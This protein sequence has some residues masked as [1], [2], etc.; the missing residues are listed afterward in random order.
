MD[1]FDSFCPS[2][3][4]RPF[5]LYN[6]ILHT[7][8]NVWNHR[9]TF[10]TT[11]ISTK[12]TKWMSVQMIFFFCVRFYFYR[13]WLVLRFVI[14]LF[15]IST[16]FSYRILVFR[17]P[18]SL[19]IRPMVGCTKYML[20]CCLWTPISMVNGDFIWLYIELAPRAIGF[21]LIQSTEKHKP[22]GYK[23]ILYMWIQ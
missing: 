8:A 21:F 7:L 19:Y 18:Y 6:F 5:S 20:V 14:S 10:S 22:K 23:F 3:V 9:K 4:C 1:K 13:K 15:S 17:F 16:L 12:C 2:I 11:N